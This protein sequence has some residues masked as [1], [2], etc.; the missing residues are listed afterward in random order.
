MPKG[1][2]N[3][4]PATRKRYTAAQRERAQRLYF[5]GLSVSEIA[6]L[7]NVEL[8][9]VKKWRANGKWKLLKE[10]TII[11][12]RAE[13]IRLKKEGVRKKDIAR[14]LEISLSTVFRYLHDEKAY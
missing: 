8:P 7:L 14:K 9:T 4:K 11:D 6:D 10:V 3:P 2:K 1:E 13:A 5:K 12:K